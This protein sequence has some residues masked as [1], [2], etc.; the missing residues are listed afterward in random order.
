ML[1]RSLSAG[2]PSSE[3]VADEVAAEEAP[4]SAFAAAAPA[5]DAPAEPETSRVP[6]GPAGGAGKAA[7]A[8]VPEGPEE[9]AAEEE[10]DRFSLAREFSQLL[11]ER[12]EG[13]DG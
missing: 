3:P 12:D 1:F 9:E 11:Q 6:E 5:A 8:G 10:I 13:A 4:E 2:V 7:Q